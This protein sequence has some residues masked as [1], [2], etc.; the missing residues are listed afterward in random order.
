[1]CPSK[2]AQGK[3]YSY[4]FARKIALNMLLRENLFFLYQNGQSK[5]INNNKKMNKNAGG[6]LD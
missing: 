3:H 4:S 6:K 5:L 2:N 1:M